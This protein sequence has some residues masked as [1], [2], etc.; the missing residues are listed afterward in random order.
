MENLLLEE[1]EADKKTR[2]MIDFVENEMGIKLLQYQKE[3][4]YKIGR[5]KPNERVVILPRHTRR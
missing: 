4:M 1:M 3:F 2:K 5:L